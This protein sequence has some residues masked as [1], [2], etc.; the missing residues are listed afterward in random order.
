MNA[1]LNLASLA[2]SSTVSAW[3]VD[4]ADTATLKQEISFKFAHE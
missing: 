3:G 2:V 1:S 4:S